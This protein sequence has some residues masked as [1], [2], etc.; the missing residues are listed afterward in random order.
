ML[1]FAEGLSP[2][3]IGVVPERTNYT[4]TFETDMYLSIR[5]PYYEN[6]PY[7]QFSILVNNVAYGAL[8]DE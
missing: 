6:F 8:Q 1:E 5:L 4:V 2:L 7:S 3:S